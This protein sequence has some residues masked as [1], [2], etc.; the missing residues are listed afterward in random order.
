MTCIAGSKRKRCH[1]VKVPERGE[2]RD[3]NTHTKTL[4]RNGATAR[5]LARQLRGDLAASWSGNAFGA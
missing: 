4:L 5:C 3:E 1:G 2:R